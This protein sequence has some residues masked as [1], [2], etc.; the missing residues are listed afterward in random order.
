MPA[1]GCDFSSTVCRS[2][3]SS[4]PHVLVFSCWAP[5][6][7][8]SVEIKLWWRWAIK[9]CKT[10]WKW[11]NV[12]FLDREIDFNAGKEPQQQTCRQ[13]HDAFTSSSRLRRIQKPN[14]VV[15]PI[16]LH[17]AFYL[18]DL[19]TDYTLS[20]H[21]GHKEQWVLQFI[22]PWLHLCL[23]LTPSNSEGEGPRG[24]RMSCCYEG[25]LKSIQKF[26][27]NTD[28]PFCW[29]KVTQTPF[30][31]DVQLPLKSGIR[32]YKVFIV[33]KWAGEDKWRAFSPRRAK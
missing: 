1:L 19:F 14:V 9:E 29:L 5:E 6:R 2:L 24:H 31:Y 28:L 13:H 4:F 16:C 23:A 12:H 26:S 8:P 25:E 20:C 7:E 33:L 3:Y 30:F 21:L 11:K 32:V 17:V 27:L 15:T 18:H 10:T 22:A